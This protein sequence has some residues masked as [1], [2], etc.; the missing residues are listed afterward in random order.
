MV[1]VLN[2]SQRR[3]NMSRIRARDTSPE[4][5]VR[6][7]VHS[8]G[9]RFRLHRRELPGTPDLVFVARRKAIQVHGCFWHVHSCRFGRV[10]PATNPQFWSDKRASNVTRDR[11]NLRK[12]R[13]L[14]WGV[15]VVWECELSNRAKAQGRIKRFLAR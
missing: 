15:L 2:R 5:F 6:R 1:D 9:Y 12:L 8:L 11:K 3:L 14:G 10:T 7:F 4:I 13:R